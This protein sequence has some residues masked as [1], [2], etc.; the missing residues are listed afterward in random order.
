MGNPRAVVSNVSTD[1]FFADIKGNAF[2]DATVM[3]PRVCAAP[4]I[5]V[6]TV[7]DG[8][9]RWFAVTGSKAVDEEEAE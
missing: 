3:L 8:M 5:L 6:G 2:I 9:M 4:I 1:G 7:M